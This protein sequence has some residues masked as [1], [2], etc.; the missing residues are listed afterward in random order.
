VG[1]VKAA[2]HRGRTRLEAAESAPPRRRELPPEQ[3]ALAE[4]YT[5]AFNAHDW[6]A[7]R[8]LLSDSAQLEVVQRFIGP[9]A[10][11]RYLSNYASN[12][13]NWRLTLAWVDGEESIVT[14]REQR[15][16]WTAHSVIQLE[17]NRGQVVRV[18]D[19]WHVGYLLAHCQVLPTDS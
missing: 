13:W 18:R 6:D 8:A 19:Y 4:Q 7:V 16:A 9:F 10:G 11:T 15:G 12:G 5:A 2:L 17:M 3:R 1:A 14:F